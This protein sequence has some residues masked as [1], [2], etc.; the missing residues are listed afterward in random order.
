M[1]IGR[2]PPFPMFTVIAAW[3]VLVGP[4][5]HPRRFGRWR[6]VLLLLLGLAAP[7]LWLTLHGVVYDWFPAND[8][9]IIAP[10]RQAI[11]AL[12]S[13]TGLAL[14]GAVA[15]LVLF[16]AR[17]IA[18]SLV[19]LGLLGAWV[20]IESDWNLG[21]GELLLPKTYAWLGFAWVSWLFNPLLL[22]ASVHWGIT[23]RR[24]LKP[25]WACQACGY[26]MRDSPSEQCPECGAHAPGAGAETAETR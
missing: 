13:Q 8:P 22:A 25:E 24:A 12:V 20:T 15:V 26:D 9:R 6:G 21:G 5:I 4:A 14:L 18:L 19:M 10:M 7:G 3:C 1:A 11:G 16:R 23:A 17:L 2:M